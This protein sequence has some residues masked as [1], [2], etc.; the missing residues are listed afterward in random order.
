MS[1]RVKEILEKYGN[2]FEG[3]ICADNDASQPSNVG[4]KVGQAVAYELKLRFCFPD[5][6]KS[7]KVDFND[8]HVAKGL[9]AVKEVIIN[10]K[11]IYSNPNRLKPSDRGYK[12]YKQRRY[13]RLRGWT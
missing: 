8:L 11:R 12:P 6:G 9:E 13:A 7:I 5:L 1:A 2:T 10:S 4:L 3:I